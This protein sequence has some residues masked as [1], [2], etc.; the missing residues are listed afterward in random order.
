MSGQ[1]TGTSLYCITVVSD[2]LGPPG[3]ACPTAAP[4]PDR[5]PYERKL[6]ENMRAK[7]AS[8]FAC[9]ESK[10][11]DGQLLGGQGKWRSFANTDIFIDIWKMIHQEGAY[12]KH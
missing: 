2:H 7:Q 1:S 9:D 3:V 11:V 10:V 6:V 8:I 4:C 5:H 12:L